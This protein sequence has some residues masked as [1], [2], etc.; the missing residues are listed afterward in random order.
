MSERH[1]SR[2]GW[3][4]ATADPNLVKHR[5]EVILD[6]VGGDPSARADVRC[7]EPLAHQAGDC[8]F[9]RCEPVG[10]HHDRGDLCRRGIID[11]DRDGR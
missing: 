6:G 4:A 11:D 7:G 5:L 3:F 9:L 10:E 8:A 2:M 1:A